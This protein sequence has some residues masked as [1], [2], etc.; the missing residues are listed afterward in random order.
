MA[1]TQTLLEESISQKLPSVSS[2]ELREFEW[3][4]SEFSPK[5]EGQK[6]VSIGFHIY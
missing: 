5:S 3:V 2:R 4:R 1:I 6:Q